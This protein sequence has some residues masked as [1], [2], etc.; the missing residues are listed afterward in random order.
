MAASRRVAQHSS[1]DPPISMSSS[2]FA[3]V[4]MTNQLSALLDKQHNDNVI[5]NLE[6]QKCSSSD[7][8]LRR[9]L[10][11]QSVTS[12]SSSFAQFQ[13]SQQP[14]STVQFRAVG[15]GQCGLVYERP[16]RGFVLKVAKAAYED[17]L[18]NDMNAHLRVQEAFDR[19]ENQESECRVPQL[20]SFISKQNSAWW[21]KNLRLFPTVHESVALPAMALVSERILPL[22]KI[23]RKILIDRYCPAASRP[24]VTANP[25][26]R[27]C[28]VRLYLGRR[29][30]TGIPSPNF[31]LRNFNLHVDQMIEMRFPITTLASSI[32]EALAV[33]HWCANVDGYDIEFVL[34]SEAEAKYSTNVLTALKMTSDQIANLPRYTDL[35]SML[36]V[37]F[38]RRTTRV[39]V[40]DFNLC[41]VWQE[42]TAIHHPEA[43]IAQLIEAFFENDPY[44]PLPL[45]DTDPEKELWEIFSCAYVS[46]ANEVLRKKD[47]RLHD[48]PR[49]FIDGCVQRER[50]SLQRGHPHGHRERKQ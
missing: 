7:T 34:G 1:E 49:R 3:A 30:S 37:S 12:T 20:F 22:P 2:L 9:V 16:G 8:I 35:E 43:V 29:S 48:L 24:Q 50:E 46:K 31:T 6:L 26:N 14:L 5:R 36:K 38:M 28:L 42:E 18:W 25:A 27:D 13:Q 44:Y 41:C 10:T 23:A 47:M 15:F 17:A 19:P 4:D 45:V 39:W 32:G 21:E 40:L 33:I 11:P